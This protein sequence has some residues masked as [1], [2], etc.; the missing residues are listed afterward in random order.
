MRILAV[1]N[2][3]PTPHHPTSGTFVEQQIKG[4]SQIGLHVE[5]MLVD[6]VQKGMRAYLGLGRQ[7]FARIE[8]VEP[9]LVH[10]MYGGAMA[11]QVMRSVTNKPTIVTFHGFLQLGVRA[12]MHYLRGVVHKEVP[13]WLNASDSLLLTSL[14]EGSPTIVKEALACNVS[15]VSV[16]VGDVS[17]RI[18]GIAGCHLALPD[19]N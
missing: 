17:E 7:I 15:V 10:V 6:R 8:H 12:E 14:H 3:Y 5:V 2:M 18:K 1:T 19:V 9:D 16:N 13:F 4:L 11:Y